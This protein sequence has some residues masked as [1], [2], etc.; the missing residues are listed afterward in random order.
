[1]GDQMTKGQG[2]Q[3]A[4]QA[5]PGQPPPPKTQNVQIKIPVDLFAQMLAG[6]QGPPPGPA[7]PQGPGLSPQQL[8]QA[9]MAARARMQQQQAPVM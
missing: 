2:Q 6:K 1:M 8:Q 9:L 3:G 7:Q 4:G 5:R